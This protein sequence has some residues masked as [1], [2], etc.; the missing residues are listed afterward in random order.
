MTFY[1]LSDL[2]SKFLTFSKL[3]KPVDTMCIRKVY[4]EPTVQF[5][6]LSLATHKTILKNVK[7]KKIL[8][9]IQR[10]NHPHRK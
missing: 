8:L 1:K 9:L 5:V 7:K 3:S 10:H 6:L 4:L 2:L